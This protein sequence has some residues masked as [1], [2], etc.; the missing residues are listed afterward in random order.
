MFKE[1]QKIDPPSKYFLIF[2]A[3]DYEKCGRSGIVSIGKYLI[4]RGMVG[5]CSWGPDCDEGHV[6]IDLANAL[7]NEENNSNLHV[8]TSSFPDES[9]EDA[10]WS[11]LYATWVDDQF[12]NQ[13]ST[14]LLSVANSSWNSTIEKSLI[15][16]DEFNKHV[17][18]K[19]DA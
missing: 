5:F 17:L 16:L 8:M 18:T 19:K 3:A 4:S 15:N 2:L 13:C 12:W 10:L 14:L 1:L 11:T 6:S 7:H 9:L